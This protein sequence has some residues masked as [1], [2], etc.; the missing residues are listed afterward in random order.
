M[1]DSLI[2]QITEC[3]ITVEAHGPIRMEVSMLVPPSMF[4]VQAPM[5]PTWGSSVAAAKPPDPDLQALI[6]AEEALTPK[7]LKLR[8]SKPRDIAKIRLKKNNVAEARKA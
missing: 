7:K 1:P 4:A 3:N 8:K 5:P 2:H 6:D